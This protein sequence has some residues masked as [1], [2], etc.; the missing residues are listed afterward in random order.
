MNILLATD[1]SACARAAMAFLAGFPLP[2]DT[3]ITVVTVIEEVLSEQKLA[4]T[5]D[6]HRAAF[7][8]ERTQAAGEAE[9]LLADNV[10]YLSDAGLAATSLLRYGH[11]AEEI[12]GAATETCCDIIVV[13][14]HGHGTLERFLLGSVSDRVFEYAP[15]SVLIVKPGAS[16]E[17]AAEP[18]FPAAADGRWHIL[19]AY[20]DSPAARKALEFCAG[21]PLNE[22]ARVKALTVLP[23]IRMFRQDVRQQLG[24]VWQ[25]KK[26]AA[27]MA[28][29]WLVREMDWKTP[30]IA[31]ELVESEDVSQA[32]LDGADAF[33]SDLIVLGNKSKKALQRFLLGSSTARVAHHA[34]CSILAVRETEIPDQ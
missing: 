10:Q 4:Q 6:E 31:T 30:D 20:D 29:E 2:D 24:W 21:L 3:G 17:P 25:E 5:S 26:E 28:L 33:G 18:H 16:G 11:P 9:R 8:A 13:G 27:E 32:I 15:C 1:G 14:S 34:S 12:V 19:L 22:R 7:E 23:L